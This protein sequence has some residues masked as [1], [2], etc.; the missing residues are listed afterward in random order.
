M[1]L[2]P[3]RILNP[4]KT[5]YGGNDYINVP[6]RCCKECNA[7]SSNDYL[8]RTLSM[9]RKYCE[10]GNWSCHFVTFTFRDSDI[11]RYEFFIPSADDPTG[12]KSFGWHIGFDHDILKRF[13]N[14]L[15]KFFERLG[16][17]K[18]H[19]LFTCEYGKQG[20]RRPH[21]HGILFLPVDWSF[22]TVRTLLERYWHYGFVKDIHLRNIPG[23]RTDLNCIKYV[24]KYVTKFDSNVPFYCTDS[25]FKTTVPRYR[26]MPRVFTSNGFGDA[27]YE[28]L[29]DVDYHSGRFVIRDINNKLREYSIPNYFIRKHFIKPC[30]IETGYTAADIDYIE[31]PGTLLDYNLKFLDKHPDLLGRFNDI[32]LSRVK[33]RRY[34]RIKSDRLLSYTPLLQARYRSGLYDKYCDMQ[35]LYNFNPDYRD[36]LVNIS[37][38][39]LKET[40]YVLDTIEDYSLFAVSRYN[41]T[42]PGLTAIGDRPFA[43]YDD[44]R[45]KLRYDNY[46]RTEMSKSYF[47][48]NHGLLNPDSE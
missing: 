24:L 40:A 28:R 39:A 4:V 31:D 43:Y 3:I 30:V 32:D 42:V 44:Y 19:F 45:L 23:R 47:L 8:V 41:S 22:R 14:S 13:K 27:L 9:Y 20:S 35:N 26:Y 25:C 33:I 46:E 29:R 37:P 6:C 21:Y 7:V 5:T 17:P 15:N 36:Y 38:T 11:P 10:L 16:L 1:C 48:R 2:N 34:Y 18:F 12:Y